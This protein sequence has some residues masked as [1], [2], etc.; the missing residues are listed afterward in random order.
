MITKNN[1]TY[2]V[3]N[4]S[5]QYLNVRTDGFTRPVALQLLYDTYLI[6]TAN[7]IHVFCFVF[8]RAVTSLHDVHRSIKTEKQTMLFCRR[9][10]S[11]EREHAYDKT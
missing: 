6:K 8:L 9:P 10:V 4:R 1:I 5:T 2:T 11:L 7:E 3:D